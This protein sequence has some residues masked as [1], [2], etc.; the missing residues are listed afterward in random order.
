[1]VRRGDEQ[2]TA[3]VRWTLNALILSEELGVTQA[4]AVQLSEEASD[5]RVKRLLGAEGDYGAR[6]G[7]SDTWARDAV[8]DVGHYGEIFERNLGQQSALDLERGLNA[9]WNARP[10]GLMY[11]LP[12]R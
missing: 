3:I 11:A 12:I 7:L 9:Q 8:A 4:N 2:W 5:P 6:L 1:M 10:R